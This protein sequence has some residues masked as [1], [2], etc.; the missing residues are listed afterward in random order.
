MPYTIEKYKHGFRL[1]DDKGHY[2]S[3]RPMSKK[4]VLQQMKAI[5]NQISNTNAL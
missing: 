1:V 3:K 4:K 2:Y 5:Q